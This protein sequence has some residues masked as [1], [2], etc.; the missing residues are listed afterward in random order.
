ML[1]SI[2]AALVACVLSASCALHPYEQPFTHYCSFASHE[3]CLDQLQPRADCV[4]CPT[5]DEAPAVTD[6]T[7]SS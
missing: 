1:R 3:L 4:P 6:N 5:A 2:A 7:H